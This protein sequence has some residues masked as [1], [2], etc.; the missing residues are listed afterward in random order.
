MLTE[1]LLCR[2]LAEGPGVDET[3]TE[4]GKELLSPPG[5]GEEA[6]KQRLSESDLR[7]VSRGH[8]R[9]LSPEVRASRR[10]GPWNGDPGEGGAARAG[11]VGRGLWQREH[12]QQGAPGNSVSLLGSSKL[13][14]VPLS[15]LLSLRLREGGP[16]AARLVAAWPARGFRRMIGVS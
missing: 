9:G 16:V 14:D 10:R 8:D 2:I 12:D 11:P 13:S 4:T 5:A 7:G 3:E 6:G 15:R 1:H